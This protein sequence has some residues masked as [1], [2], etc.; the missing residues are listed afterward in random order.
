M[1]EM[2]LRTSP[3]F[4]PKPCRDNSFGLGYPTASTG[5]PLQPLKTTVPLR[6]AKGEGRSAQP[7]IGFGEPLISKENLS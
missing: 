3:A 7:L 2:P 5:R 1:N 4:A 6:Y